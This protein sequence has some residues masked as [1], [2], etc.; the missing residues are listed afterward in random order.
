M[1]HRGFLGE[2]QNCFYRIF[3]NLKTFLTCVLDWN[4]TLMDVHPLFFQKIPYPCEPH[5]FEHVRLQNTLNRCKVYQISP[6]TVDYACFLMKCINYQRVICLKI[7]YV[8]Q[9]L[10]RFLLEISDLFIFLARNVC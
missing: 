9:D 4:S 6:L 7:I 10:A 8:L 3:F 1:I 5:A 2:E